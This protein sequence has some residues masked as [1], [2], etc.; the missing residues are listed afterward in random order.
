GKYVKPST[1]TTSIAYLPYLPVGEAASIIF[2]VDISETAPPGNHE[3]VI[4]ADEREIIFRLTVFGKAVLKVSNVTKLYTYPGERGYRIILNVK[5]LSNY[6]VEDVRVDLYSPFITGT[7]SARIGEMLPGEERLVVFEV[8]VDELTPIGV[9]PVDTRISWN[10][11]GRMLSES[12]KLY[13][14]I[15]KK[16]IP[17]LFYAAIF[18]VIIGAVLLLARKTTLI[19]MLKERIRSKA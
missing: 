1:L 18:T 5:N 2:L 8:D 9:L 4:K 17:F 16:K 12:S 13:I 14:N 6:T 10:Q 11:E 15:Y 7:T 19:S 3:V